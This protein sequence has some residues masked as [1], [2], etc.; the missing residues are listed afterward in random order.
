MGNTYDLKARLPSSPAAPRESG[1]RSS[2]CCSASGAESASGTSDA[3]IDG[4]VAEHVDVKSQAA[5]GAGLER[6]I[7]RWPRID[8]SST[9]P[10]ISATRRRSS[11]TRP[12][13]GGGSSPSISSARCR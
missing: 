5:I 3:A 4:V 9:T 12:R 11:I 7:G 2:R 13:I 1:A 10:A 8:C 6:T